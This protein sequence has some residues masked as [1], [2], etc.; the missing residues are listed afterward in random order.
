M[1]PSACKSNDLG[2]AHLLDSGRE[3]VDLGADEIRNGEGLSARQE[4]NAHFPVG[5][6]LGVDALFD[7]GREI[8]AHTL[9]LEVLMGFAWL[10]GAAGDLRAVVPPDHTAQD[11]GCGVSAH[12]RVA[13]FPV[14][15]SMDGCSQS[16]HSALEPVPHITA[17]FAYLH[18]TCLASSPEQHA[19]I[20]CLSPTLGV[21]DGL[22]EHDTISLHLRHRCVHLPHVAV[23]VVEQRRHLLVSP[24]L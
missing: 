19:V 22:I 20:G 23:D 11:M 4:A 21:E 16:R 7:V 15:H 5:R 10:H 14:E 24:S 18:D 1:P 17:D 2:H 9:Q 12:Q 3:Q 6:D 13:A 8:A